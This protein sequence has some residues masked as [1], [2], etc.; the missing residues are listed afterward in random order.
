MPLD[1]PPLPDSAALGDLF[2]AAFRGLRR[3]WAAQLAPFELTPH[4]W[5]ALHVLAGGGHVHPHTYPEAPH[6][7]RPAAGDD[8]EAE[9]QALRLN[10]L[11]DRLRIAPRSATEVVDQLEV[12]QLVTRRADPRDRRATQVVLTAQGT[13]LQQ[14]VMAVRRRE[15]GRFFG[16]LE[17]DEQAELAR[18]LTLLAEDTDPV[19]PRRMP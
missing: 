2:H 15:S 14:R 5:R 10:E 4:Q 18:L 9:P 8:V 1:H 12:K 17:T 13:A 16:R 6:R 11:A 3:T 7:R 19:A